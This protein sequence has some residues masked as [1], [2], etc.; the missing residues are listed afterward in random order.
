MKKKYLWPKTLKMELKQKIHL[1]MQNLKKIIIKK[2]PYKTLSKNKSLY[3]V[4]K[5]PLLIL[6]KKIQLIKI[7]KKVYIQFLK[8][9]KIKISQPKI[10]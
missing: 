6:N 4:Q 9:K 3:K 7:L 5:K 10:K 2:E 1:P 8:L